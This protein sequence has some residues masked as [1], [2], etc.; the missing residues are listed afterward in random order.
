MNLYIVALLR[1]KESELFDGIEILKKLVLDTRQEEGCLQ[2]DLV[3]DREQK[4]VF[5]IVER[6]LDA[7]SHH[8]HSVSEHMQVFR[9]AIAPLLEQR[10]EV[11][12]G[13]KM[14]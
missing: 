13:F 4:G 14:F 10:T 7:E 3:E 9:G 1:L 11:Y 5:F 6:W 2:Y 8:K 12:R